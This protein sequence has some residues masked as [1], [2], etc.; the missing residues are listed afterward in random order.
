MTAQCQWTWI[1][2]INYIIT[3]ATPI[4]RAVLHRQIPCFKG[5]HMAAW[6][7]L[8]SMLR[9]QVPVKT[10]PD[11]CKILMRCCCNNIHVSIW[12][13]KMNAFKSWINR[14][15]KYGVWEEIEEK[16]R[17]I[18]ID[19]QG[20]ACSAVLFKGKKKA[21]STNINHLWLITDDVGP[22]RQLTW[23]CHLVIVLLINEG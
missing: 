17:K 7:L 3:A 5:H 10:T 12:D 18:L 23:Q 22:R 20:Y 6:H 9:Y 21:P 11:F 8:I 16:E 14:P 19:I 15:N 1:N 13:L 2:Y 4:I